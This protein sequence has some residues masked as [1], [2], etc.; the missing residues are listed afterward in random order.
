M[1]YDGT[2]KFDTLINTK[3]FQAGLDSMSKI[4]G[5]AMK[6]TTAVISTAATAVLGVG[7]AAVKV[8]MDFEAAMSEVQALSGATGDEFNMLEQAAIDAGAS[9]VFSA[10]DAAAALKYM[11]LAGWD[12]EKSAK[13]LGGVLN[14]AA[15]SGMDLAKASDMVTDY[16]SAF[17]NSA[18]SAADFA[19]L[20]AYAQAN[21]N[22]SAEQLGEAYKNCA[23]NLNAAGQ[24]V[25]TVTSLLEA[26]ANQGEK[27]STAGTKLRAVMRDLTAQMDN[28]AVS[29]NGTAIA[30]QDSE[31]N[32]RDLTDILTDVEAATNGMGDAQ[33]A[34]ALQSVFTDE[35][36]SGLN[37]IFNEGMASVAGY[38]EELRNCS[39]TAEEM[40]AVMNDNLK[41]QLTLLGSALESLG[42]SIYKGLDTPLK[43]VVKQANEYVSQLQQAFNK[44]GFSGM[45]AAVGDVLA[46]VLKQL[47]DA[48][49]A[50]I[51]TAKSLCTTFINSILDHAEEFGSSGAN[52]V[53]S[54]VTAIISLTGEMWSAAVTLFAEFLRGLAENA[55][56]II[57]T[58]KQAIA[59]FGTALVENAPSIASSALSIVTS[60]YNGIV[61]ALP[62]ITKA[63]VDI[64]GKLTEGIKNNLP[65][66]IPAA[67]EALVSFS[68]SLRENIGTLVD[69]GLEMIMALAQSLIDNIPVFIETIPT[70]I[71]NICGIINDNAPKL[72]AAGLELIVQ[73]ALGLVQAIPTLIEN[74]PQIIQ[75]VV[76][77]FTAFNWLS[78][79]QKIITFIKDGIKSLATAIPEALKNIGTSA[80]TALQ[81]INWSQLGSQVVT[82]IVN[83]V[84][85]L[86]MAIPN[87]LSAIGSKAVSLFRSID[88]ADLGINLIKGI[89][90]GITGS[91]NGVWDAI[92]NLCTGVLDSVKNFFGIHSPSTVMEEQGDYL[93]QGM[94]NGFSA[95]PGE[96]EKYTADTLNK[97]TSWGT[98]TLQ[99]A[100]EIGKNTLANINTYFSQM[101]GKIQHNLTTALSNLTNWSGNV[102]RN[103]KT[104]AANAVTGFISSITQLPSKILSNLQRVTSSVA[105]WGNSLT[106]SF[107]NI[108]VNII[109]GLIGGITSMVSSLYNSI[110]NALS[111]LVQQAKNALGIH[112]PSKVF[113]EEVGEWLPP[114][115]GQGFKAAMPDLKR[116]T[117]AELAGLAQ[118]MKATV[119]LETEKIA[120]DTNASQTYKASKERLS[121]L[122]DAAIE[123]N[124][125]GDI[126][127]H[128]D[129]DGKEVGEATTPFV[130]KNMGR[131][132]THKKRGG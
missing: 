111:G 25:Q 57:E 76:A 80:K 106:T 10:S 2:L 43:E 84:K 36:I 31:G 15:A 123:V 64:L 3:S 4:A 34:A 87:A 9:T 105:G 112:S 88:W 86:V 17:S 70:I 99:K 110:V 96:T 45:V 81:N 12:A 117:N 11:S 26:M 97:L 98:K 33:K 8:G 60:L 54:L 63:G 50:L 130:D 74:I 1:A 27:G 122:D 82:F 129:L 58:A 71:T 35:A 46:D 55:P 93:V 5:N 127:T 21:S 65:Q 95:L 92:G 120:A 20:L 113:A 41:G 59:Q 13:E 32:F 23:A 119:S 29:I 128:V 85:S 7:T 75:A 44:D 108:G 131:I 91:L 102:T 67:M 89:I 38:E 69:A 94:M 79:G 47:M 66:M 42:I 19:D 18:I 121:P 24:D 114:G 125:S 14:L 78:L 56:N 28:G 118:K 48:A 132:D 61:S 73:L 90:A 116:Q 100:T 16:L 52:L 107:R 101:P 77:A 104:A 22:T 68:S 109:R 51:D 30:V 6:A 62:E 124:I 83:G 37:L 53:T 126:H 49:P 72:L 115:I 39:G 103:M 40:A